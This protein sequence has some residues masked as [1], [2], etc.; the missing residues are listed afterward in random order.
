MRKHFWFSLI[1]A[2]LLLVVATAVGYAQGGGGYALTWWTVDGGGGTLNNGN[3]ALS[4]TVGQ[5]DAATPQN[6]PFILVG[7]F[8]GRVSSESRIYLPIVTR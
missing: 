5:P 8:W 6:G 4:T 3:Y 2:S 7:G 1:L